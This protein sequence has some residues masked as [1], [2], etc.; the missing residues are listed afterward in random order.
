L[1]PINHGTWDSTWDFQR[2]INEVNVDGDFTKE[3]RRKSMD[4]PPHN[5]FFE[6]E[7]TKPW[8]TH[9]DWASNSEMLHHQMGKYWP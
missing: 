4:N 6:I 5:C 8:E 1:N 2:W 9:R 3:K 7:P